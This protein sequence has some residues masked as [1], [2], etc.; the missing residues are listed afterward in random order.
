MFL[1][2]HFLIPGL[3]LFLVETESIAIFYLSIQSLQVLQCRILLSLVSLRFE[4]DYNFFVSNSPTWLTRKETRSCHLKPFQLHLRKSLQMYWAYC[5]PYISTSSG[6][7]L[8][9][10]P[11]TMFILL[12]CVFMYYHIIIFNIHLQMIIIFGLY[13]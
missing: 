10:S 6:T 9:L 7:F 5:F 8:F 3:F 11:C 2:Y 13:T 12:K 4:S 1:K